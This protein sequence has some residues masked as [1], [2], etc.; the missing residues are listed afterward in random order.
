[1]KRFSLNAL[2]LFLVIGIF[3]FLSLSPT[4]AE[5][6][7]A[8]KTPTTANGY[9]SLLRGN[10]NGKWYHAD[11]GQSVGLPNGNQLFVYGD[12][13]VGAAGQ[14]RGNQFVNNTALMTEKGCV[15]VLIGSNDRAGKPTS[16]IVPNATTDVPNV[17][18]YYWSSTPF[19]DGSVLRVFVGH[20]YNDA[21]GFHSIGSD[22][23]TFNVSGAKPV[24]TSLVK[25]PGSASYEKG[26]VWGAAVYRDSS[27]TYIFGSWN[28]HEPYVFGQYYYLA[29]V[30]NGNITNQAS[31]RYWNG[32]TW[33]TDKAAATAVINGTVGLGS[34]VTLYKKPNGQFII[35][36]KKFDAF[37]TDLVA[38]KAISLIGPWTEVTPALMSP[39]PNPHF[40]TQD[41]SYLG[42]AASQI[43]MSSGKLMVS[44][45]YNSYDA[46]F[47]GDAR[48]GTYFNEVTKP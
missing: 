43:P 47:F 11:Y 41:N 23:A 32:S 21:N 29:R 12:T 20:M 15:S 27:Y 6:Y 31:W 5:A 39:I 37:G 3:S 30:T 1:M 2:V 46:S 33:V 22:L 4:P 42:L 28:K 48:Y 7:C 36:G 44:Y 18:D 8:T 38:W 35:V 16:W 24:L 14:A 26:P 17:N 40:S 45:S 19:M 9:Q 10:I 34:N 13:I 25:T